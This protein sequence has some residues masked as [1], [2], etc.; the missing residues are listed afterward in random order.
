MPSGPTGRSPAS[1]MRCMDR[2]M[3]GGMSVGTRWH[4]ARLSQKAM[5]L[6]SQWNRHVNGALVRC[7]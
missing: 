6:G 4:V 7:S 3:P 1:V 5:L 2:C